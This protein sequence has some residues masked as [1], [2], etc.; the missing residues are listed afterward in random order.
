MFP[1]IH[2]ARIEEMKEGWS[3]T[4]AFVCAQLWPALHWVVA[5]MGGLPGVVRDNPFKVTYV[6]IST[7]EPQSSS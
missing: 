2:F 1:A 3:V 5:A 4:I 6:R 7:A